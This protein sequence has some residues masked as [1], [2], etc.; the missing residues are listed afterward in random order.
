MKI[1]K[2]LVETIKKAYTIEKDSS[3]RW[4]QLVEKPISPLQRSNLSLSWLDFKLHWW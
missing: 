4:N 3:I 1:E 2:K